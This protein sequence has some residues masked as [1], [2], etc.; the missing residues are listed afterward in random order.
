M[1]SLTIYGLQ[2]HTVTEKPVPTCSL[3]GVFCVPLGVFIK[4]GAG[5]KSKSGKQRARGSKH[6]V[7]GTEKKRWDK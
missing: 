3:P 7:R 2:C 5:V 6:R 1:Y 4:H